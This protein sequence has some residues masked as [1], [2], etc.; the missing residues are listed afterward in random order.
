MAGGKA[1]I[2]ARVERFFQADRQTVLIASGDEGGARGGAYCGIG[3]RLLELHAP[4]GDAV[5]VGRAVV[6]PA[7]TGEVGITHV[8]GE[9]EN[10]IGR[11]IG[12]V[13]RWRDEGR[14]GGGQ[15][16]AARDRSEVFHLNYAQENP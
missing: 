8:V 6:W 16:L 12:S 4:C 3:I 15:H 14:G 1:D 2:A 13:E 10:D 9:D 5:D 7:V 11:R